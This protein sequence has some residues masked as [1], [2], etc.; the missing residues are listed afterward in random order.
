MLKFRFYRDIFGN[1]C[2]VNVTDATIGFCGNYI[3]EP[4]TAGLYFTDKMTPNAKA[5]LIDEK[6]VAVGTNDYRRK[7]FKRQVIKSKPF[8]DALAKY[9]QDGHKV[10][11]KD[12]D[13][14][15]SNVSN[16]ETAE[17]IAFIARNCGGINTLKDLTMSEILE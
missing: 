6:F 3:T 10:P 2:G 5:D 7:D 12:M 4:D 16:T 13:V 11:Y 17:M 14:I 1:I 15:M 9:L 8:R